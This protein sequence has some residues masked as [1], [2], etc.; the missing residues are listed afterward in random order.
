[1]QVP[2]ITE[3]TISQI[4]QGVSS[5]EQSVGKKRDQRSLS[6]KQAENGLMVQVCEERLQFSLRENVNHNVLSSGCITE[7]VHLQP[8]HKSIAAGLPE[9]ENQDKKPGTPKGLEDASANVTEIVGQSSN[10]EHCEKDTSSN[11]ADIHK[12]SWTNEF[13]HQPELLS[14]PETGES[15]SVS[16]SA[17]SIKAKLARLSLALPPLAFDFTLTPIPS[18]DR[19][20]EISYRG[21]I[22]DQG[23]EEE[24]D[25]DEG[26]EPVIVVTETE[27]ERRLSL[28]SLLKSPRSLEEQMEK[29]SEREKRR[30]VSFFDDVTVYLFDQETPTN[31]LSSGSA[32]TSPPSSLDAT[33]SSANPEDRLE[34]KAN[35][36]MKEDSPVKKES[37]STV[38]TSSRFTVSPAQ[39]PPSPSRKSD[40]TLE[41]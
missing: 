35:V 2:R 21:S 16:T 36:E 9:T 37:E 6:K 5:R 22:G 7:K 4:S 3:E 34:E 40:S 33:T 19:G 14:G 20:Q 10:H 18:R 29:E 27:T 8:W 15:Q 24:D 11:D 12:K 13:S 28:R 39:D 1:M 17:Q 30:N 23:E 38:L 25:E 41:D 32:P 26:E 31:E